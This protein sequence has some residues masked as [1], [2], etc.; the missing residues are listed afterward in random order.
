MCI[1]RI[2]K[3]LKLKKKSFIRLILHP[4]KTH[5]SN[6]L[7]NMGRTIGLGIIILKLEPLPHECTKQSI[8]LSK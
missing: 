3:E 5:R 6:Q 4:T 1:A 7:L 8:N 2:T